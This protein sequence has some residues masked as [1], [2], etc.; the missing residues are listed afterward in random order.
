MRSALRRKKIIV[1]L[2]A[3]GAVAITAANG[4][5]SAVQVTSIHLEVAP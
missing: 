3:L 5:E 1:A 2:G 4:G